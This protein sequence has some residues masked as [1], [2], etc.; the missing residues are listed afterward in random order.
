MVHVYLHHSCPEILQ[1]G[2]FSYMLYVA[3]LS[4]LYILT[5]TLSKYGHAACPSVSMQCVDSHLLIVCNAIKCLREDSVNLLITLF[6]ATTCLWR[7]DLTDSTASLGS[8]TDS[9][10]ASPA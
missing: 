1:M 3:I 10:W 8:S 5:C 2:G 6:L 4:F 7:L 9:C